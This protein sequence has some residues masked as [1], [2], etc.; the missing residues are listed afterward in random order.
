MHDVWILIPARGGSKGI[1]GKNLRPLAGKP[2]I[3]YVLE[4]A[5]SVVSAERVLVSTDDEAIAATCTGLCRVMD[6]PTALA[7]D[8]ATLDQVATDVA[9]RLLAEG[10]D[11]A[12]ILLTVQP[13]S[14][15]LTAHTLLRAS[16]A[17]R[18][19]AASALTVVDDRHLRWTIE[20]GE[21]RPMFT[22]R[23]NRQWL[24]PQ[25]AETGGVI[26]ARI[27]DI[28]AA[29]T[30]V[31]APV[32]LIEVESAEGLDIDDFADWAVAEFIAA[33]RTIVIR[34]DAGVLLGMGHIYRALALH[35]ELAHHDVHIVTRDDRGRELG[36]G[37]LGER[38]GNLHVVADEPGFL[39]LL[40]EIGPDIVVLDVLDTDEP[41]VRAVAERAR[42]VVTI[43]DM[44]PGTACADLVINDLY[45]DE[46]P[47]D[48]HLYGVAYA[49]L[50]PHFEQLPPIRRPAGG[51]ERVL[52]TFGGSD[53]GH[54]TDK[55]LQALRSIGFSGSVVAVLGPG[56][57]HG[58][59]DLADYGLHGEVLTA[60]TNLAIIMHG[61]DL[62]I[63]SAGRTVT[64]L[65]TQGV[66][67]ITL[68]QNQ[69]EL[70][71]SHAA[72]AFGIVNLGLGSEVQVPDL[73]RSIDTLIADCGA[74]AAM[75]DRMLRA[76]AG[77]S[78]HAVAELILGAAEE[79]ARM[80]DDA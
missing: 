64:E 69:R 54:L 61:A 8:R 73:A 49:I 41:F 76:V 60:V 42:F 20:G 46:H 65:M 63:T 13:T 22:G 52:V 29:A 9:G 7:D 1:P 56:F 14:P 24:E 48:G 2:L 19:G 40:S 47:A 74:R 3:T 21:P 50:G 34:A 75:H 39:D 80:T 70:M 10:A 36:A 66:P 72:S 67:T 17:L 6:R 38:V 27:T 53:P 16:D 18:A 23:V 4:T 78:N 77:R 25:L 11:G 79:K 26:G 51:V 59:V 68:C 33:R 28:A 71:H 44:G 55:A 37:F 15:F 57:P 32:R 43:E 62:A 58:T 45:T 31:I 12:D 5:L 35:H 30:R